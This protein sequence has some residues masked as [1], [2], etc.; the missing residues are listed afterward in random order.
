MKRFIAVLFVLT[1]IAA[2]GQEQKEV[3]IGADAGPAPAEGY[4]VQ[5]GETYIT[6]Q[7]ME[8]ELAG[9]P[10]SRRMMYA[11][12]GG[13]SRLLDEMIKR[14]MFRQEAVR[15]GMD[16]S[17]EYRSRVEYLSRLAL[18]E[19]FLEEKIQGQVTVSDREVRAYNDENKDNEF[20]NPISGETS[21][22][23]QVRDSVRRLLILEKQREVFENYMAELMDRYVVKAAQEQAVIEMPAP[24]MED[25]L[26]AMEKAAEEVVESVPAQPERPSIGGYGN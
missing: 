20:T 7:D 1:L 8:R 4:I 13:E 9:M 12:P 23:E 14:E 11:A 22:F 3:M 2:C 6:E 25:V 18:V 19:M 10:E 21:P 24:G 5:V 16:Q 17:E 15:V 26:E